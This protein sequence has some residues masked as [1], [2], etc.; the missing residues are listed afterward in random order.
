MFCMNTST[1]RRERAKC[2]PLESDLEVLYPAGLIIK[3]PLPG[4]AYVLTKVVKN[5]NV[6]ITYYKKQ[7]QKMPSLELNQTPTLPKNLE[8]EI[9]PEKKEVSKQALRE[10]VE[11]YALEKAF[12]SMFISERALLTDE[13][14]T[15]GLDDD[16]ATKLGLESM[17]KNYDLLQTVVEGAGEK[18]EPDYT[19]CIPVAITKENPAQV[20]KLIQSIAK[21]RRDESESIEIVVWANA[22]YSGEDEESTRLQA[23]SEYDELLHSMQDE[24]VS[25]NVSIKTA[26]QVVSSD[27]F[28]MS[29]LRSNYMEAVSIE[30]YEEGY[31]FQ[32]PVIWLD[33]DVIS[34]SKGALGNLAG[35]IKSFDAYYVH[36]DVNYA[37][38]WAVDTPLDQLDDTTK[39]IIINETDRRRYSKLIG[40]YEESGREQYPEESGLGFSNGV[41]L[42]ST[43]MDLRFPVDESLYLMDSTRYISSFGPELLIPENMSDTVD[44]I[45]LFKSIETSK[46]RISAR[47]QYE[48]AKRKG[49][50]GLVDADVSGYGGELFTDID[51]SDAVSAPITRE[52]INEMI[53]SNAV[54]NREPESTTSHEARTFNDRKRKAIG[55]IATRY[56][57]E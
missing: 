46:M 34:L 55:A 6:Y 31:S 24:E 56:F 7:K 47:R 22:K 16:K 36:A 43:G 48:V 11:V 29:Q 41:Y 50:A 51:Q 2:V 17:Y 15:R 14:L 49:A 20:L 10:A 13:L 21:S 18:T 23:Q 27:S 25:A 45:P 4:T 52:S 26:L 40:R 8:H 3:F 38:D 33:A 37:I 35:S 53:R 39:A 5:A 9:S 19:I 28:S 30:G 12:S 57:G 44:D 1:E 42:N 54:I 32:R